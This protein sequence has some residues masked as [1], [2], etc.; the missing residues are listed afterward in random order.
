MG[1]L[2]PLF[3][4]VH[5]F[6]TA[7]LPNERK[8]SPNTIRAYQKS[9]ELLLDYVKTLKGIPLHKVT[10]DMI[11]RNT[12]SEFL[13]YLENERNCTV[14]TRNQR[15]NAIRAFY[16]YAAE[17]DVTATVFREEIS[18]VDAANAP[19]KTIE[20]MSEDAIEAILAQPNTGTEKGLRDMF[21]MFFLFKT[22]ARIQELLDI[23]LS[24]IQFGKS[25][26]VTLCGKGS[27]IRSVPLRDNTSNHL[28]K[29]IKVFHSEYDQAQ[30]LFYTSRNGAKKRMTE[31]N[32]RHLVKMYGLLARKVCKEVPENVHPHLFRHSCAMTLYQSGVDLT[33]ISQWLGH[34][35]LETTLIYAHADTEIKRKALENAVPDDSPL[36][37]HI[38]PKRYK[39]SDDELLKQLCG[40]R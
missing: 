28:N 4:A 36:A 18:K 15:L 31:D 3:S 30:Y 40:L 12:L 11:D 5:R 6:F 14:T 39:I 1:T 29:Y 27:K 9:L 8:C 21:L 7:Y 16:N 24:D 37:E 32:A 34:A 13:D 2:N 26:A 25:P 33:L 35:N 10:F 22:G 17:S 20:H 38:K 23:K 19:Q